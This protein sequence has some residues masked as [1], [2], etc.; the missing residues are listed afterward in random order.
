MYVLVLFNYLHE[1]V[2]D[3]DKEQSAARL[4]NYMNTGK[5]L[6]SLFDLGRHDVTFRQTSGSSNGYVPSDWVHPTFPV[7]LKFVCLFW[8]FE[9]WVQSYVNK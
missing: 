5:S 8:Y 2:Y 7:T 9:F 1:I 3:I 6:Y 4:R